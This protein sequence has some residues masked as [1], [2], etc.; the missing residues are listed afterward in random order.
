MSDQ[1]MLR[2][3]HVCV[4]LELIAP[5]GGIL[6]VTA[7]IGLWLSSGTRF[8]RRF[9]TTVFTV[10]NFA[11]RDSVPNVEENRGCVMFGMS[12]PAHNNIMLGTANHC[13]LF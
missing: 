1:S 10:R 9:L 8:D 6:G 13:C 5:T 4:T 11:E 3:R 7:I 2:L 12:P